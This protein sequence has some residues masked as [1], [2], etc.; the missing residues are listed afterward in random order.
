MR[1]Y[2]ALVAFTLPDM[3]YL[4]CPGGKDKLIYP[5]KYRPADQIG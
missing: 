5:E 3:P 2:A 1:A 4:H